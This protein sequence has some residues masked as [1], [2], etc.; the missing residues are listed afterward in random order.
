MGIQ[1]EVGVVALPVLAAQV[2]MLLELLAELVMGES[3]GM[4]VLAGPDI[5][6]AA[7]M[8]AVAEAMVPNLTR[9]PLV[10]VGGSN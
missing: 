7:I 8:A 5:R 10:L 4:A 1:Q 9:K 3:L 6:R 2:A